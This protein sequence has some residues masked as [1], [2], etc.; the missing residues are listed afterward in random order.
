LE[1][2]ATAARKVL[3]D[4]PAVS[5]RALAAEVFMRLTCPNCGAEYEVPDGLVP[6]G[7]KHVQCTDC[8]TRWF[9]RGGRDALVSEDQ[10][11][12]R[13]EKWRPRLV[14]TGGAAAAPN[15]PDDA[16]TRGPEA[17]SV[18]PAPDPEPAPALADE[19]EPADGEDVL[20]DDGPPEDFVWEDPHGP[21]AESAATGPTGRPE[22]TPVPPA[23]AP[24]FRPV[25]AP[26]PAA[27]SPPAAERAAPTVEETAEPETGLPEAEAEDGEFRPI[28]RRTRNSQRIELPED[29]A[30][31]EDAP[32]PP[33]ERDRFRTGLLVAVAIFVL[34]L[35]GYATRDWI[36][37]AV[38][39]VEPALDAYAGAVD[40]LRERLDRI[41][42]PDG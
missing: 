7:G 34:A 20:T 17:R 31:A 23:A 21:D 27:S 36:V 12:E 13:L 41:V 1:C 26:E 16:Q 35:G 14:A 18:G 11:I 4:S 38:P 32:A 6:E 5:G 24:M 22:P 25:H 30:R 39:A 28:R 8:D 9:V 19:A 10:L 2:L 3:P 29:G 37:R 15:A 40:T 33:A 42:A